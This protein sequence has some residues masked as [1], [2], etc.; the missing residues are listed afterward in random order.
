MIRYVITTTLAILCFVPQITVADETS[1][2]VT[3]IFHSYHWMKPVKGT[4]MADEG[5]FND[6]TPGIFISQQLDNTPV[7]AVG[8]VYYNSEETYSLAGGFTVTTYK[9]NNFEVRPGL[10]VA[11]GYEGFPLIPIPMTAFEWNHLT[12][13]VTP[14]NA[15]VGLTYGF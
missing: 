4:K 3:V 10:I 2:D 9:E 6:N 15:T 5:R 12:L 13:I 1:T 11:T 7:R 8:G 14:I